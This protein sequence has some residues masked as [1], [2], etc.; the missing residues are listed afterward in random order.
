M[1]ENSLPTGRVSIHAIYNS[2]LR[3]FHPDSCSAR[4][5][6]FYTSEADLLARQ[7]L[8]CD[9]NFIHSQTSREQCAHA[10]IALRVQHDPPFPFRLITS[11]IRIDTGALRF[12]W[13]NFEKWANDIRET[14]WPPTLS[15]NAFDH[16]VE[17]ITASCQQGRVLSLLQVRS[18]LLE[19]WNAQ[20]L[21]DT[22]YRVLERDARIRSIDWS[23]MDEQCMVVT[24]EQIRGH[25]DVP[26]DS[27]SGALCHFV[28]NMHEMDHQ[29]SA[30][31]GPIMCHIQVEDERN[32]V[33]FPLS[34]TY[35]RMTIIACIATDGSYRKPSVIIPCKTDDH[36]I[37]LFRWTQEK[38]FIYTQSKSLIDTDIFNDC[39]EDTFVCA[40]NERRQRWSYDDPEF[41]RF[42]NYS[43]HRGDDL[44][45]MCEENRF[46]PIFLLHTPRTNYSPLTFVHLEW[47]RS[48]FDSIN[49]ATTEFRQFISS[50]SSNDLCKLSFQR[51]W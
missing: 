43:A 5:L 26:S 50:T 34:F 8:E 15:S 35:K 42:S 41:L 29:D 13:K 30:D 21:K 14:R 25:F 47:R 9:E 12:H 24:L 16:I 27:I 2:S 6:A 28:F 38:C 19:K 32:L 36:D 3:I 31:R 33:Y 17:M 22:L 51:T 10:C 40:L 11:S 4:E 20:I 48:L 39:V 44:H 49:M 18:V 37:G 45:R 1:S 7:I 23:P 46:V